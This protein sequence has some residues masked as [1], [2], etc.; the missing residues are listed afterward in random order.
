MY[1]GLTSAELAQIRAD[2]ATL[3]PEMCTILSLTKTSDGEGGWTDS[4]G[5]AT[6]NVPC[7]IDFG[8]PSKEQMAN[9]ELKPFMQGI[10]SMAYDVVVTEQ[11]RI[12]LNG[13]TYSVTGVNSGQSWIGSK[14]VTV[15][16][17]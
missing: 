8:S 10:V 13:T 9:N 14:Q 6:A 17:V 11:N 3:F 4:W 5:T 7:R 16:R 1:N 12:L 15:Q 2:I